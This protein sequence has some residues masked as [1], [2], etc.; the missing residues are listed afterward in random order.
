[1]DA[2]VPFAGRKILRNKDLPLDEIRAHVKLVDSILTLEPLNF[3]VAGG[4]LASNIELNGKAAEIDARMSISARHLKLKKL[5]PAAETMK[6]S[7]GELH[8]DAAL[9]GRGNSIASLLGHSNGELKAL[10]SRGAISHLLL[11]TAG[12][13][14]ANIVF[15]K[16]FGD[17]QVILNCMAADFDIKNGVMATRIF[18]LETEDAIVDVSGQVSLAKE[19]FALDIHP[20]NKSLR[21]FT[22]RTPLYVKGTFKNPDV[23]VYKGPLAARAGAAV[24]LG[25]IATPFAALLP[26]LNTGT[27]ES[28]DCAPLLAAVSDKPE[29][30]PPG[31]IK[32]ESP[33][34]TN[35]VKESS[36]DKEAATSPSGS[37]ANTATP[38]E[39]RKAARN[40]P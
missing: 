11:E 18:K 34:E 14:V 31:V 36:T 2:D 32:K 23:G 35:A 5:F 1:M 7:F 39:K 38:A 12:L 8:G 33:R 29:A 17:K 20:E 16:L 27:D 24:L 28:N 9:S 30:P 4:D 3:G 6:A 26:L 40:I 10:V 19:R 13:N 25:A 37:G 15:L 22:L 21:I